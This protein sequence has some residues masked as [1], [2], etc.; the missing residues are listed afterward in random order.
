MTIRFLRQWNGYEDGDI[1]NLA[2]DEEA[3]LAKLGIATFSIDS[4]KSDSKISG[5][6]KSLLMLGGDHPQSQ[7]RQGLHKIAT[8]LGLPWYVAINTDGDLMSPGVNDYLSWDEIKRIQSEGAEIV[9]HATEPH[10][11]DWNRISTGIRIKY[12][13][14]GTAA[15][16]TIAGTFPAITIAATVTGQSDGSLGWSSVNLN[17]TYKTIPLLVAYINSIPGWS[18]YADVALPSDAPSN[19]LINQTL[20]LVFSS[21]GTPTFSGGKCT[22]TFTNHG[23]WAGDTANRSGGQT[24]ATFITDIV[25]GNTIKYSATGAPSGVVNLSNIYRPMS[26]GAGIVLENKADLSGTSGTTGHKNVWCLYGRTGT[27]FNILADGINIYSVNLAS[28]SYDTLV[29][30]VA[31]INTQLNTKGIFARLTDDRRSSG[32]LNGSFPWC[33]G[34]EASVRIM[35]CN[36]KQVL[37]QTALFAG[38]SQHQIVYNKLKKCYDTALANGITL[39]GFASPGSNFTENLLNAVRRLHKEI[40]FNP[41]RS[42]DVGNGAPEIIS[43]QYPNAHGDYEP[44]AGTGVTDE[45][46]MIA[47]A[48]ALADSTGFILNFLCHGVTPDGSSGYQLGAANTT[49]DLTESQLVAFLTRVAYHVNNGDIT[50]AEFS[51]V[52]SLKQIAVKANN[53]LFNPRFKNAGHDHMALI[54]SGNM[55]SGSV[56]AEVPGINVSLQNS[57]TGVTGV[58]ASSIDSQGRWTITANSGVEANPVR[59]TWNKVPIEY[60][61]QYILSVS[62]EVLDFTAPVDASL[63]RCYFRVQSEKQGFQDVWQGSNWFWRHSEQIFD[64][65]GEICMPLSIAI[66][67][68]PKPELI[69]KIGPFTLTAAHTVNISVGQAANVITNLDLSGGAGGSQT[70]NAIAARINTAMDTAIAAGTV[71]A[72]YKNFATVKSN[73]LVLTDPYEIND[74]GTML[75]VRDNTGTTQTTALFNSGF[76]TAERFFGAPHLPATQPIVVQFVSTITGTIRISNPVLRPL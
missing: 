14:N 26:C 53:L 7:Y 5:V 16:V 59:L 10:I 43:S 34:G 76:P 63:G 64:V 29:E 49:I 9:S 67:A 33:H 12:T 28:A 24:G 23:F 65:S 20:N 25:D 36:A 2:I 54:A 13:G 57:G 52:A 44:N 39:D 68:I 72:V 55:K 17:T 4:E 19:A 51:N 22:A 46:H 40:R 1:A 21:T 50:P 42:T 56:C 71:D 48:D 69:S 8:K 60:G 73:R 41:V 62:V 11:N 66:P 27:T 18:C 32:V 35:H 70:A 30:L 3:R 38:M 61:K 31:D 6:V 45:A 58:T 15:S 37:D 47:L 75:S 74:T